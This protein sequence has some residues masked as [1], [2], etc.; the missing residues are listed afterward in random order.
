MVSLWFAQGLAEEGYE[1]PKNWRYQANLNDLASHL[2]F[3]TSMRS[4]GTIRECCNRIE[5]FI[6]QSQLT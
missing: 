4:S 5:R 1:L 2:E 3:L 6:Q